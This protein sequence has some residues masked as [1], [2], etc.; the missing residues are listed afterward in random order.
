MLVNP[1]PKLQCQTYVWFGSFPL[2][3]PNCG[4]YC[5]EAMLAHWY[6]RI[7]NKVPSKSIPLPCGTLFGYDPYD[8]NKDR[9]KDAIKKSG[10]PKDVKGWQSMLDLYGPLI[11]MGKLGNVGIATVGHFVLIVGADANKGELFYKD[12]LLGDSIETYDFSKIENSCYCVYYT[13]RVGALLIFNKLGLIN[14][15]EKTEIVE[16]KE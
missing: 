10:I 14:K 4:W 12:P 6:Q 16:I 7:E 15:N 9:Y 1:M 5:A 8:A 2:I 3:D 13:N 11:L